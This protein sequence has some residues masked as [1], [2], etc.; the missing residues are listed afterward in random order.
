MTKFD[1]LPPLSRSIDREEEEEEEEEEEDREKDWEEEEEEETK[2]P[3][4]R[5]DP[6]T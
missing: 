5:R 6:N 4:S 3:R 1:L 2:V